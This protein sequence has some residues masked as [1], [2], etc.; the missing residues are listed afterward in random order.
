MSD[1]SNQRW[2]CSRLFP[3]SVFPSHCPLC[4]NVDV[5]SLERERG[6]VSSSP[7]RWTAC[8]KLVTVAFPTPTDSPQSFDW[9]KFR[10][11]NRFLNCSILIPPEKWYCIVC[12]P[13]P[14]SGLP[15]RTG[16][17]TSLLGCTLIMTSTAA[18]MAVVPPGVCQ[19]KGKWKCSP[20][21]I[22]AGASVI[23]GSSPLYWG[24]RLVGQSF[25][26]K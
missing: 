16:L 4:F 11:T 23:A 14:P 8:L 2:A 19:G 21:E 5:D 20:F 1:L 18:M 26:C 13:T 9:W 10:V 25:F 15:R 12:P 3:I 24:A 7:P 22:R 17:P 6:G